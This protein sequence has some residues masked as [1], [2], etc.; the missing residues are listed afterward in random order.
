MAKIREWFP[1]PVTFLTEEDITIPAA[2]PAG[3]DVT[4]PVRIVD[5]YSQWISTY[6]AQY[7][8]TNEIPKDQEKDFNFALVV[9]E[10][11]QDITVLTKEFNFV[12]PPFVP[13]QSPQPDPI[14]NVFFGRLPIR[15]IS[16]GDQVS[17]GSVKG[18]R[19]LNFLLAFERP[20]DLVIVGLI[21]DAIHIGHRR[22]RD[23]DG[24]SR[25]DF[26]WI[27]DAP[28]AGQ[29]S[30]PFGRE[31]PGFLTSLAIENNPNDDDALMRELG[32][33]AQ[34]DRPYLPT[35]L[36]LHGSHGTHVADLA[37]G[38]EPHHSDALHR[39]I[40]AVQLPVFAS[41]DTSG[42]SLMTSIIAASGYIFARALQM[43]HHYKVPIPV[44]VNF[45]YGFGGG[46]RIGK[47]I[48][49]RAL[50]KQAEAYR[51]ET[52]LIQSSSHG[53]VRAPAELVLPAG[54]GHLSQTHAVGPRPAVG[55]APE[56]DFQLR[57]Q[58][59]DRSSSFV[60]IWFSAKTKEVVITVTPPDGGSRSFE[61]DL[62][63]PYSNQT[64]LDSDYVLAERRRDGGQSFEAGTVIARL[65]LDRPNETPPAARKPHKPPK[66]E[67]CTPFWRVVLA[68]GP[69][70]CLKTNQL[71]CPHG[72]W[73]VACKGHLDGRGSVQAWVQRDEAVGGF[74]V[75]GRQAYIE[76][77]NHQNNRF[78]QL[79]DVMVTDHGQPE[80][81]V[82]RNGTV[83]GI[84]T[85]PAND[86]SPLLTI[87]GALWDS[88]RA[89]VY[90][91][92]GNDKKL[93]AP[94]F[95]APSDSSRILTGI[96]AAATRN[97]GQVAMGGTSVAAPQ[98]VRCLADKLN[99]IDPASYASF[100]AREFLK[101]DT[102]ADP[103]SPQRK[104]R[105]VLRPDPE[106]PERA[107]NRRV[108]EER[109]RYKNGLIKA[110]PDLETQISRGT[111]RKL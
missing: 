49:E 97:G 22:F 68:L 82:K 109:V 43:S 78:D 26:A 66:D 72:I 3:R 89:A 59:D 93:S 56:L 9:V 39:R 77:A 40:V 41:Q 76:D 67:D 4:G 32:L 28:W 65:S 96:N 52:A 5:A 23:Q 106:N 57:V 88:D 80:S 84:A 63:G 83:S 69:S 81:I 94:H 10:R 110:H 74:G 58:P 79:G 98:V 53:G 36:R 70:K 102:I 73:K 85:N 12:Q 7:A 111:E 54:N 50:R 27:H 51:R 33:I 55:T 46:P 19:N 11:G 71:P 107:G 95:L 30:V 99:S 90:S 47:H 108:R 100:N 31:I 45:S 14:E 64:S 86:A 13:E 48:V 92:A 62:S 16:A 103:E 25:V 60:E 20:E 34:E 15:A 104:A 101:D 2:N 21:D 6:G 17:S 37:A 35:S 42:T 38:Y 29:N 44:V 18:F 24:L 61:F 75:R 87:G 105:P 8:F 1:D 91:S